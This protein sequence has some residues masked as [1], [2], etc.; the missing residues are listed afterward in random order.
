MEA[1]SFE[2]AQRA[3]RGGSP[4]LTLKQAAE[5]VG[6]AYKTLKNLRTL[7]KGPP[8][9]GTG[10]HIDDLDAWGRAEEERKT[11]AKLERRNRRA[12]LDPHN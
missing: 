6:R 2:R 4:L 9:R 11:R 1:D 12:N 7:G 10:F 5:Y 8:R 3:R